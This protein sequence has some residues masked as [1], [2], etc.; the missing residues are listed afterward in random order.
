MKKLDGR[1]AVITGAASGIGRSTALA[2]ARAGCRIALVDINPEELDETRRQIT[3]AGGKA[4]AFITDVSDAEQ[5][6]TLADDVIG[7]FGAVHIVVNNAGINVTASFDDHSL[8]DFER[9]LGVNLFGVIH[10]CHVFLPHLRQVDEAHIVNVSSVFGIVGVAGHA[11]YSA[12][13]FAVRG[14]SESLFEELHGSSIGVSV[15]HP[16][17]INT[18][19]VSAST[20]YDEGLRTQAASYFQRFG[21]SPDVVA[22]RIVRAI[23]RNEHRVRVT[24]ETY[25]L[26]WMRRL[27]PMTGNHRA[28]RLMQRLMGIKDFGPTRG[29]AE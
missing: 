10:G 25:L 26:D 1:I 11:A 4:D 20:M 12:S 9:V 8:D 28:N 7:T 22:V 29:P 18:N 15:V 17:C 16:G 5:M 3:E 6:Q 23:R 27:A 13:K 24:R 2:L 19:I 14:L 21:V